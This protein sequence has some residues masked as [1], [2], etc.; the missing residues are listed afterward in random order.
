MMATSYAKYILYKIIVSDS[1]LG[2]DS[3]W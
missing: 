3:F 1:L 2:N